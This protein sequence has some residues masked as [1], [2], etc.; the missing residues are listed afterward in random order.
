[1]DGGRGRRGG[2]R[3]WQAAVRR[4]GQQ[5]VQPGAGGTRPAASGVSRGDDKLAA[6]PGRPLH[7]LPTS[8]LAPPLAEPRFEAV[9]Q[10]TPLA[11]WKFDGVVAETGDPVTGAV[12]GS[13]GETS[14][15]LILLGG[16]YLVARGMMSWRIP[17]AV[18]LTVAVLSGALHLWSP[19]QFPS[20]VFML[21]AGGLMLGAVFMATDPVGSPMTPA[22]CLLYGALIGLLVVTIRIWGGM[23]EGVMY[24]ILLSNAVAPHL[25]NWLQPRVYGSRPGVPD[26]EAGH[27]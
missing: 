16:G 15:L 27:E 18:L 5:P 11:H 26:A 22:G 12:A 17:L 4:P 14:A 10:P 19:S 1:M 6:G 20:P 25:D 8:N 24:A 3:H 13:T 7:S 21:G 23:P 2:N 9:S